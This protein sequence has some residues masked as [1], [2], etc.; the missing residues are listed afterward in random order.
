MKDAYWR[1]IGLAEWGIVASYY[2][3]FIGSGYAYTPHPDIWYPYWVEYDGLLFADPTAR[4]LGYLGLAA[5]ALLIV[6][7]DR[8]EGLSR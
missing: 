5:L 2:H 6:F 3:F 1:L 8:L 4:L 7:S